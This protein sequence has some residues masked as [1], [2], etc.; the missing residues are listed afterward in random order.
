MDH[1]TYWTRNLIRLSYVVR[2]LRMAKCVLLKTTIIEGVLAGFHL[3]TLYDGLP[4]MIIQKHIMGAN[5]FIFSSL[6]I[7]DTLG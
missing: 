2:L 3:V 1:E 7:L 5:I 6:I 4:E